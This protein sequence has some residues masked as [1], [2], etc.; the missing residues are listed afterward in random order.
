MLLLLYEMAQREVTE[1][2]DV[3]NLM[4]LY[5]KCHISVIMEL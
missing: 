2:W 5:E 3:V 4:I 1:S